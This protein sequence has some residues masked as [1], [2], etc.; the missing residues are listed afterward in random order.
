MPR[1]EVLIKVY[2]AQKQDIRSTKKYMDAYL[3]SNSPS[4]DKRDTIL[5]GIS[6]WGRKLGRKLVG[7][8]EIE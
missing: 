2:P 5:G 6:P 3:T 4:S 7:I 1:T 8:T